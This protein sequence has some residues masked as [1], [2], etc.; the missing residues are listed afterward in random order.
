MDGSFSKIRYLLSL[1]EGM[2]IL[3][4][5]RK[6]ECCGFGGTYSVTEPEVSVK[7]GND[8]L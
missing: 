6:D 2:E 5:D 4:L 7:M 1:V 8:R 3:N